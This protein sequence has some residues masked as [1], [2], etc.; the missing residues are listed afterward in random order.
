[1]REENSIIAEYREGDFGK[2]LNLYLGYRSLRREFLEV[3]RREIPALRK[4]QAHR[5]GFRSAFRQFMATFL[6]NM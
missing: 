5:P 4:T 3:D 1:M 2:R 6:P